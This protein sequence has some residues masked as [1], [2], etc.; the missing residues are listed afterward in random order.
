MFGMIRSHKGTF[1]LIT[2]WIIIFFIST[3]ID[4]LYY[5]AGTGID[6]IGHEYY[7]FITGPLLHFGW[8]H[9]LLNISGMFW[10]G[11]FIEQNIGSV[12][13][14]VFG[15]VASTF[16]EIIYACIYRTSENNIGGSVYVFAF[17]GLIIVLQILKPNFPKFRLG[18]W[19]GNWI[20]S[21]G[22]LGNVPFIP[23]M[24]SGTIITHLLAL[25][26]GGVLGVLAILL[27]I[28]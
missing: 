22:I 11:Y 27:K 14:V 7:R 4:L 19:Y 15:L 26:I 23:F 3:R 16:T 8:V 24:T 28:I 25:V 21:Y 17:I 20:L 1:T 5:L 18:T 9:L 13:L 12:K 2:T 10:V 6:N